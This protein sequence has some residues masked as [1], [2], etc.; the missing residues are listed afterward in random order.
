MF[1]PLIRIF[2]SFSY[3]TISDIFGFYCCHVYFLFLFIFN[4][5]EMI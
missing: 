2:I 1:L 4:I 5:L 3:N